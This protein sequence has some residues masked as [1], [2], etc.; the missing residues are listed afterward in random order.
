MLTNRLKYCITLNFIKNLN[1]K[2]R[3]LIIHHGL[4]GSCKNFRSIS[5]TP[6]ISN[7]FNTY[8]IDARNHGESPH[9]SSH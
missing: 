5:K 2:P 3:N 8:S 7:Y 4:M 9:T 1:D 6:Q